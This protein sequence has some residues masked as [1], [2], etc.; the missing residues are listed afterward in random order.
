RLLAWCGDKAAERVCGA[1]CDFFPLLGSGAEQVVTVSWQV[2]ETITPEVWA[3]GLAPLLVAALDREAL[4]RVLR[5]VRQADGGPKA[6]VESWLAWV[7]VG[8]LY[9]LEQ[10]VR[11]CVSSDVLRLGSRLRPVVLAAVRREVWGG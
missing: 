9:G 7:N 6:S 2:V 8:R 5:E 1:Y 11:A 4:A 10:S 3:R